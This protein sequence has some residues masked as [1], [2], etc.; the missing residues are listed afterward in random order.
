MI[1]NDGTLVVEKSSETIPQIRTVLGRILESYYDNGKPA[2]DKLRLSQEYTN[3]NEV[4]RSLQIFDFTL[5]DTVQ[6][7][8]AFWI[9]LYNLQTI[10]GIVHFNIKLT[11]WERPNFFFAAEYNIGGYRFSLY[12]IAHGVLRGNRRRWRLSLPPFRGH[13]P[14]IRFS[15]AELDPRIHFALFSG[16]RSCPRPSVYD[17]NQIDGE[18]DAAVRRFINSDQFVYD[19]QTRTLICSKIF[20][21]FAPDFGKTKNERLSYIAP[22]VDDKKLLQTLR[23]DADILSIKYLPYDWHLNSTE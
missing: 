4:V 5:L 19:E 11:V 14:R 13:D 15:I 9:N 16:S 6:K 2:Y 12:D 3:L 7:Q 23:D 20:K 17:P 10:H 18:L 21:W 22:F 1:L 8:K